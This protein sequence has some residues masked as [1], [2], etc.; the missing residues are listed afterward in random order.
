[1]VEQGRRIGV[2][3][4][5][6]MRLVTEDSPALRHMVSLQLDTAGGTL[7]IHLCS[8]LLRIFDIK[9]SV[10]PRVFQF[11]AEHPLV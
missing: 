11:A 6:L 10:L 2:Q 4:S 3:V 7:C 8:P 1:M 9:T 5:H